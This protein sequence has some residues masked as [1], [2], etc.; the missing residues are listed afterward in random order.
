MVIIPVLD[1]SRGIAVHARAGERSRYQRVRSVLAPAKTGDPLA[2][3]KAF[4][5]TLGA[6][7]C[8]VADLDS[9]QGGAV[10][11]TAIRELAQLE[12]GFTGALLVDAGTSQIGGA[13]E[14]LACG[15]S[16]VVVGLESLHAFSDLEIIVRVI[17]VSRVVFS[18]DLRLGSPMLHS[19]LRS[20]LDAKPD[21]LTLAARAIDT[22][23][24]S[25]L[26][27]D[28]GRVGTGHGVDLGLL[29]ELRRRFGG[30]RLLAG[31][32]VGTRQDLERMRDAGCDGA[33]VATALHTGQIGAADIAALQSETSASR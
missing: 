22:G 15:A 26:L 7:A 23:V 33:L 10:Q 2:L 25:L 9:I 14:V 18:L 24:G 21:P 16:E 11:R 12:A 29:E 4:R 13:V 28:V 31:G 30:A 8:Y 32:G 20:A 19:A 1:L 5:Q 6:E 3:V 27:L 17:G